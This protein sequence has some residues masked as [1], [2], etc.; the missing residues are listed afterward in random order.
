MEMCTIEMCKIER[1]KYKRRNVYN[2]NV[3]LAYACLKITHKKKMFYSI[4]RPRYPINDFHKSEFEVRLQGGRTDQ[5][6]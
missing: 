1:K 5:E 3:R 2:N 6:G 4:F